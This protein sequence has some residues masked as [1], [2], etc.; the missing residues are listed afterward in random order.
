MVKV[1]QDLFDKA[2]HLEEEGQLERALEVWRELASSSA[3]RNVFLRY[4]GAAKELGLLDEAKEAFKRALEI[5]DRSAPALTQLGIIALGRHDYNTAEGYLRRACA[6]EEDPGRFSLLGVALRN[7]GK[8]LEA[9]EAYRTAIRLDPK[10]E[11]T[12]FN[13]GVVLRDD[14]PSEA[15]TLFRKALELDPNFAAAHRELCPFGKPA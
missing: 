14:R 4:G 10:Y 11:E 6:A 1:S 7:S 15:Q 9:E 13:L 2:L 5:D 12:H 8:D 3:T